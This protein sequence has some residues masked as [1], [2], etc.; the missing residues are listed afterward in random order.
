M[1]LLVHF[2]SLFFLVSPMLSQTTKENNLIA[3]GNDFHQDA[4]YAQSEASYR[5]A[6]S[7]NNNNI[8][9]QHNLGNAL[10]RS[11]DYKQAN[12][13]YFITQKNSGS[14]ADKHL[15]F[16]NMGN[17]YMQQKDYG[18]AVEAYK[19]ALRNNPTDDTTR[20]NYALAKE[21]LE[22]EKQDDQQDQQNQQD[23]D[24]QDNQDNQ[25]SQNN[26]DGQE[27]KDQKDKEKEGDQDDQSD[28]Q[29]DKGDDKNQEKEN[30]DEGDEKD[31]NKQDPNQEKKP[32]DKDNKNPQQSP[33][34]PK[35]KPG[36]ISPE[37]VKSL[38]DAMNQQEK[39]VQ[40]KVN[41]KKAKG[42]PVKAKKD[43]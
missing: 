25:D 17:G 3:D 28:N 31:N 9:A 10:Y 32:K 8:K 16:H 4:A 5:K 29:G 15:A 41:A 26:Q 2:C 42:V 11:K 6:L 22:K 7:I 14:K 13:H 1:K 12:Q 30:K 19:N 21:L 20:Y 38:L 39:K 33:Q 35:R 37:Q 36:Q 43:W 24:N 18:K 23:K 40:D 34:K 27:N